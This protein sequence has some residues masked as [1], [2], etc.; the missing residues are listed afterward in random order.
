M[1]GHNPSTNVQPCI[2]SSAMK[3]HVEDKKGNETSRKTIAHRSMFAHYQVPQ[4]VLAPY[5]RQKSF[6]V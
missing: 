3:Y 4:T 1:L 2:L 5:C 6:P